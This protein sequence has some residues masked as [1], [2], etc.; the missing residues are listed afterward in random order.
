M[1]T[2]GL[3]TCCEVVEELGPEPYSLS[4]A[5]APQMLRWN[6]LAFMGVDD[7]GTGIQRR[8]SSIASRI[9]L[10]MCCK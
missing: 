9:R 7:R 8:A 10:S 3:V 2:E 1:T 5:I 6:V 4:L